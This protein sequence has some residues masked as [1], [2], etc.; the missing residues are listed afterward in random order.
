MPRFKTDRF[1]FNL[2]FLSFHVLKQI[3][4]RLEP[5]NFA[6]CI[7]ITFLA[8]HLLLAFLFLSIKID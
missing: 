1:E 2:A 8:S 6:A 5:S 7:S 4:Y 3:T